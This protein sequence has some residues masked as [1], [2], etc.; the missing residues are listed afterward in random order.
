MRPSALRSS[1]V[2]QAKPSSTRLTTTNALM[3]SI[4]QGSF[5]V[6][7]TH[8]LHLDAVLEAVRVVVGYADDARAELSVQPGAELP[9][10]AVRGH[11]DRL[12][13]RDAASLRVVPRELHLGGGPL[14]RELR[15]ALDGGAAEER[16]EADELETRPG[17]VP[18][19]D[20]RGGLRPGER[21][22]P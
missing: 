12:A 22:G 5:R 14:E 21:V 20:L 2:A 7:G 18:R 4:H 9:G 3:T 8:L 15:H 13:G 10:G 19:S 6:S 16:A 17:G 1:H 11:A